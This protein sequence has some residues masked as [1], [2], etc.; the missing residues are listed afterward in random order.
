MGWLLRH[1]KCMT[2]LHFFPDTRFSLANPLLPV[3]PMLTLLLTT[4]ALALTQEPGATLSAAMIGSVAVEHP[5]LA[6]DFALANRAAVEALVD[7]SSKSEFIPG[8][9]SRSSDPAIV[10]K[11]NAYAAAYLKPES[12]KPLEQ[13]I[14]AIQTRIT[15][16]PRI[17]SEVNS[18]LDAK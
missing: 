2:T 8:L 7:V 16:Q 3:A 5:D 1:Y 15:S 11:L 9:A 13:V 4:L 12:R 6:V 18:W 17:Q 14:V 10:G